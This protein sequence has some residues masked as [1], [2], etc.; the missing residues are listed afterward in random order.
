MIPDILPASRLMRHPSALL[1][2]QSENFVENSAAYGDAPSTGC[3]RQSSRV[4]SARAPFSVG[5]KRP[6]DKLAELAAGFPWPI[7]VL[8]DQVTRD[9]KRF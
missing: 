7:A 4:S 5:G 1:E 9:A 6:L 3:H 2:I 8:R